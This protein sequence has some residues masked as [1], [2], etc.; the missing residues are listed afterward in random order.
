MK[1]MCTCYY[2]LCRGAQHG[3]VA[4]RLRAEVQQLRIKVHG[5]ESAGRK[6]TAAAQLCADV[7]MADADE[8]RAVAGRERSLR[9]A[10]QKVRTSVP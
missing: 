3:S 7:A 6:A 4:G 9:E 5:T 1:V 2:N 10:S 8:H